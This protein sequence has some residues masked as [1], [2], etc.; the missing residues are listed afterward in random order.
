MT[1]YSSRV[2][3]GAALENYR[4]PWR[5]GHSNGEIMGFRESACGVATETI[6]SRDIAYNH[7]HIV[8]NIFIHVHPLNCNHDACR[9]PAAAKE[10]LTDCIVGCRVL[11]RKEFTQVYFGEVNLGKCYFVVSKVTGGTRNDRTI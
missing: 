2:D 7:H 5:C 1:R 4:I 8:M 11:H 3:R 6:A 10:S 9:G